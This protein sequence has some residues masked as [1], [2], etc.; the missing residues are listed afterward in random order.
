MMKTGKN[1]D[2][3]QDMN[4]SL[5]LRY[6][7]QHEGC[8]RVELS[9]AIGLTQA[10]ITKIIRLLMEEDV[11]REISFI[12]GKKGRRSI[13]M[14][15][16]YSRFNVIAVKIAWNQIK[17]R[18][19]NFRNEPQSEMI[20]IPVQRLTAENI[21]NTLS[22]LADI[23]MRLYEEYPT[24]IGVGVA[25]PGPY[26]RNSG[27]IFLLDKDGASSGR[28]YPLRETLS[29]LVPLPVFSE[30]DASAGALG[31]WWCKSN[32]DNNKVFLHILASEGIGV[33]VVDSGRVFAIKS[34]Q[35]SE[36][37]H[38]TIDMNG[39]KCTCGSTGCLEA[40][41]SFRAIQKEVGNKLADYPGSLLNKN[42]EVTRGSFFEAVRR[43]DPL[44]LEVL[45]EA[46]RYMGYGILSLIPIFDPDVIVISDIL[47]DGG[48]ILL[49]EVRGVIRK[50]LPVFSKNP[51]LILSDP[52]ED[53]VLLGAFTIAIDGILSSPKQYLGLERRLSLA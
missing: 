5:I 2:D 11:V 24:V 21:D 42:G 13:G 46:S 29:S 26:Q 43:Q 18:V 28:Y 33:G 49:D 36:M 52:A 14:S 39:R 31:Y 4:R 38:I 10:S 34:G 16:N 45:S 50:E 25:V 19:F 12:E 51:Q 22:L 48:N 30:Y 35:S 17:I 32:F 47:A 6:L 8:S 53:M 44:A 3:I 27:S 7:I 15:L 1:L 20:M 40:Y 9:E 41:S 37:G 23:L